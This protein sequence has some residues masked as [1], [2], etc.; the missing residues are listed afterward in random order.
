LTKAIDRLKNPSLSQPDR[1]FLAV[2]LL[3]IFAGGLFVIQEK[4]AM[5]QI[6]VTPQV[7]EQA[8]AP[9]PAPTPIAKTPVVVLA[10]P[11]TSGK[12]LLGNW[13]ELDLSTMKIISQP[14]IQRQPDETIVAEG[15]FPTTHM[16]VEQQGDGDTVYMVKGDQRTEY[17]YFGGAL[18]TDTKF[19]TRG[20][21]MVAK[22]YQKAPCP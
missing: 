17:R 21:T 5:P 4:I 1:W 14:S 16:R 8:P 11:D 13:C 3:S 7:P 22:Y 9:T 2:A 18:S 12:S 10:P 6:I 15:F 19:R 20:G